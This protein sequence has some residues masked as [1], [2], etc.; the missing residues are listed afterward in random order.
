[1]NR[2]KELRR[3]RG[4]SQS[5]LADI[6]NVNQTAVSQWERGVTTPGLSLIL[7][8]SELFDV[9]VDYLMTGK[10]LSARSESSYILSGTSPILEYE[11]DPQKARGVLIPVLGRVEAGIPI[12]AV[13]TVLGY[14]EISSDMALNGDFFAL[15]VHGSSMEPRMLDGDV[16]IVR[17]QPDVDSG[18]VAVVLVNGGEATIKRIKKSPEG[19]MLIPN[20]SSFEPVFYN[21]DNIK[22]LPVSIL[23]KVIELRAKF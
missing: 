13:E 16:V 4:Y 10:A 5:R 22:N 7:K 6:L 2:I 11:I 17:S 21:N 20:N 12:S 15:Q 3:A 9:S 23:G 8:M 14:E 1:M 19:I 18:D